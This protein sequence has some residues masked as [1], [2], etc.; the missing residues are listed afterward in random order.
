MSAAPHFQLEG[1]WL[2]KRSISPRKMVAWS[3]FAVGLLLAALV[4]GAGY[5]GAPLMGI[6]GM[7]LAYY[8]GCAWVSIW[9]P[10][11]PYGTGSVYVDETKLTI[12]GDDGKSMSLPLA[13]LTVRKAWQEQRGFVAHFQTGAAD[14]ITVT[15]DRPETIQA[16]L[17]ATGER[18]LL[19][20]MRLSSW[21]QGGSGRGA[22]V[23][24]AVVTLLFVANMAGALSFVLFQENTASAI[25][26]L[27]V[28]LALIAGL[29]FA[30]DRGAAEPE[31]VAG[32]DGLLLRGS[33]TRRTIR[34][35]DLAWAKLDKRG[36]RLGKRNGSEEV[37]GMWRPGMPDLPDD[38]SS[39][40]I[41]RRTGIAGDIQYKRARVLARIQAGI[42]SGSALG[43]AQL[44]LLDRGGQDV[45]AWRDAMDGL[46]AQ[47]EGTYRSARLDPHSLATVLE[48]PAQ[49][50]A[51]RI[52]ATLALR[53]VDDPEL[54][55]RV[56]FAVESCVDDRLRSALERATQ[57]EVA[58]EAMA[59][60][61]SE[62]A[63][64]SERGGGARRMRAS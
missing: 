13:K 2:G 5:V 17:R 41:D 59:E 9:A 14:A 56:R 50:L 61:E 26:A 58:A 34:Y 64:L 23:G 43:D 48:S 12:V 15:A 24:C 25:A 42:A 33:V 62:A 51:R 52:G 55:E 54:Q 6:A 8:Y 63:A 36:I 53:N 45:G 18:V 20:K 29:I 1:V 46:L 39:D 38:P 47:N 21:M 49:P 28:G 35:K 22:A 19:D 57:G 40:A 3:T 27:V 37:L 7:V 4:P 30:A 11:A 32:S 60:L 16:L 10:P 31:L 44:A